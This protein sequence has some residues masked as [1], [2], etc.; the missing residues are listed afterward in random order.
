MNTLIRLSTLACFGYCVGRYASS[1]WFVDGD[2]KFFHCG[3]LFGLW[4]IMIYT[5]EIFFKVCKDE[6]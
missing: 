3:I 5:S 4:A 2:I 6:D 1:Q